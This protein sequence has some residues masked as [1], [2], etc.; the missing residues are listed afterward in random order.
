M[1]LAH[2]LHVA[3]RMQSLILIT[4]LPAK[5]MQISSLNTHAKIIPHQVACA[6]G[7]QAGRILAT[8][9]PAQPSVGGRGVCREGGVRKGDA[10]SSGMLGQVLLSFDT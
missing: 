10:Q 7:T 2:I 9:S 8:H 6:R 3:V 4:R 5:N 1:L